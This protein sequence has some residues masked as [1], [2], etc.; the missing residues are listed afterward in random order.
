MQDFDEKKETTASVL[1]LFFARW[2]NDHELS[3]NKFNGDMETQIATAIKATTATDA[4][5]APK[6]AQVPNME[7]TLDTLK[8]SFW[9]QTA[10]SV[11][12]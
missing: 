5:K 11:S 8:R 7:N 6:V 4:E 1:F 9:S 12:L 3:R 10:C 2:P